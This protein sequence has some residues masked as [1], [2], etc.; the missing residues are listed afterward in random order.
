MEGGPDDAELGHDDGDDALRVQVADAR[1]ELDRFRLAVMHA[2]TNAVLFGDRPSVR[3]GRY[4]LVREVGSGGGG[5]VFVALDPELDREIAIK[6]I[7][8]ADP[9]LRARAVAEGQSLARLAH[10]NVVAVFDVGVADERVY[11]AMEL[12]RGESLRDHAARASLRE[13]IRAY[14]QAGDGLV[15]AHAIGLV[16]R[17]FK[18]DNAMI[19]RDGRVRVVDFGL[20]GAEGSELAGGTPRYMAPEQRA[21]AATPAVDQFAFGV[22]L[23]EAVERTGGEPRW[24]EPILRRATSPDP[25]ARFPTMRALLEALAND[26]RARWTRRAWIAVPIAL[27][28]V[29][30]GAFAFTRRTDAS[31]PCDDSAAALAP[32]WTEA[33]AAAVR[34]HV[35]ELGT[36]FAT[37][38]A[39]P[40]RDAMTA[41]ANSWIASHRAACV[42]AR[43]EPSEEVIYRRAACLASARTRL[44]AAIDVLGAATGDGLPGALR[45]L[46]ERPGLARCGDPATLLDDV[47]RPTPDRAERVAEIRAAVDRVRVRSDAALP[48]AA[49][50][51][52]AAVAA[53]RALDYRPLLAAAL[54]AQ[55]HAF[56]AIGKRG[57]GFAALTEAVDVAIPLRDDATA[58]EAYAR[59][60]R[61]AGA[62]GR[63]EAQPLAAI[64]P[65]LG[66]AE[67]VRHTHPFAVALLR[68]NAGVAELAAGRPARARDEWRAALPLAREVRGAGAVELAWVRANLALVLDAGP[69]RD[70]LLDEAVAVT[71]DQLGADHPLTL[72]IAIAAAFART[73]SDDARAAL[74]ASC[75]RLAELH[76][77]QRVHVVECSYEL[78]I[79][80]LHA[81]DTAAARAAFARTAAVTPGG[82]VSSNRLAVAAAFADVLA[83]QHDRARGSLDW[84]AR[85]LAPAADAPWHRLLLP[86]DVELARAWLAAALRDSL[87]ERAALDRAI[88]YLER[89][90]EVSTLLVV[91]RRL[92]AA[93][94][95]RAAI[96]ARR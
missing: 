9:A 73:S 60:L 70:Q 34:D 56:D 19:G 90:A 65:V 11:L 79:L 48:D 45:G 43:S 30:A 84:L 80:D 95:R 88:G 29:I 75:D 5:S 13:V 92:D 28:A 24:L 32:A 6:L 15:A 69:E 7:P 96:T 81:G 86:S 78:G 87:G 57:A 14:R 62:P 72:R 42:A 54:L 59:L 39:H 82:E 76:P 55:G 83:G 93:R 61:A 1:P 26:P 27:A 3:V 10:P 66:L 40:A 71:R 37:A 18:P 35:V 89:A 12:V 94:A 44:G 36:A 46:S 4:E 91:T 31:A 38:S 8:A 21:G 17:D 51:A 77:G 50:E 23:R 49:D 85:T 74:R 53:A 16:H 41:Y 68:N 52:A 33:R 58:V 22:S 25:A 2:N 47:H 67:R 63:D 20:A 64:R